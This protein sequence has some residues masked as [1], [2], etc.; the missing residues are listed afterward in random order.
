MSG[1][2]PPIVLLTTQN[3]PPDKGGIQTLMGG[4]AKSLAKAGLRV[5]VFA[6]RARGPAPAT[7]GYETRRFGGPKPLRRIRK[8]LALRRAMRDPAVI[9]VF[10]DTWKSLEWLPPPRLPVAV[11]AHGMEF[12][13]RASP[14]KLARL[15]RALSRASAVVAVSR[16]AADLARPYVDAARQ[17]LTVINNPI[18][19]QPA[20]RPDAV[21][22]V[23]ALLAGRHPVLLTVGRLEPRK[24]VD[25]VLRALPALAARFPALTYVVAGSGG[26]LP[27]LTGL[28]REYGVES[29]V[30]FLG[31]TPDATRTA[32]YTA[33]DIFVMP[34]RRE[35]NSVE[36][37]G[38]VY[39][40]AAWHG[41]PSIAGTEGGAADAVEDGRTGLLCDGADPAAVEAALMALLQ[42]DAR[43][44]AMGE[45]AAAHVRQNQ[46]WDAAVPRY[47]AL[48]RSPSE[49]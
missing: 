38:I 20:P 40:E 45:A 4:L 28:A 32:L 21:A 5:V 37:F 6:D 25:R 43:R 41:L 42:D 23:G 34:A 22:E 31:D 3:F 2:A 18:L 15:R 39:L 36:G 26:D 49:T 46:L 16:Y 19:P 10:A 44:Q 29:R 7:P 35:G 48:L 27:R 9:G 47:L 30:I 11:L 1:S 14:R 13:D 17:R 8:A 12:P 24:G 33:A